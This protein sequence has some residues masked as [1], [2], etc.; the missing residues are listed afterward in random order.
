MKKY[1]PFSLTLV[2]TSGSLAFSNG[3]AFTTEAGFHTLKSV[4]GA[5]ISVRGAPISVRGAPISVRGVPIS[6]RGVPIP[7]RGAPIPVRGAPISVRGAPISVRGAHHRDM[8]RRLFLTVWRCKC[9]YYSGN[10]KKVMPVT[11]YLVF[12][13]DCSGQVVNQA[14]IFLL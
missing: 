7:V 4:S 2:V 8:V 6:V 1:F 3:M 10:S 11:F 9:T 12:A 13:G 5:N 14:V